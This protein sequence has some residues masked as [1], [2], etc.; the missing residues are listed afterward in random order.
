GKAIDAHLPIDGF[1]LHVTASGGNNVFFGG[2]MGNFTALGG[3]N[4]RFLIA[5]PSLLGIGATAIVPDELYQQGGTFTG[6][7]GA[8]HFQFIGGTST[9]QFGNVSINEPDGATARS[10][11]D[12]S[13]FQDSAIN[14]NM[15]LTSSQQVATGL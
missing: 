7:G 13:G 5:D 4:N 12:F 3:G 14:L 1:Q 2:L 10:T 11:L 15:A 6:S 9:F 8:D